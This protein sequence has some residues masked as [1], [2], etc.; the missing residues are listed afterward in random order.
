VN[1]KKVKSSKSL[2]RPGRKPTVVE[3]QTPKVEIPESHLFSIEEIQS[4]AEAVTP[5]LEEILNSHPTTHPSGL[6]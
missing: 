4:R 6:F 3:I 1:V 5:L 2:T